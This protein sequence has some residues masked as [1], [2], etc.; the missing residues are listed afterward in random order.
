MPKPG[1]PGRD[2]VLGGAVNAVRTS[3]ARRVSAQDAQTCVSGHSDGDG[4]EDCDARKE[5]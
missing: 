5:I 1:A 2:A 4:Q 3:A